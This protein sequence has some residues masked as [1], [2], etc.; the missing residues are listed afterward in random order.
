MERTAGWFL[1]RFHGMDETEPGNAM[2]GGGEGA[3]ARATGHGARQRTYLH[4]LGE[5]GILF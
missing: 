2:A 5:Q 4:N 3:P 1:L